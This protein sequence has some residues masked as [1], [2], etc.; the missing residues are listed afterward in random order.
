MFFLYYDVL[1]EMF[2]FKDVSNEVK[3]GYLTDY[4]NIIFSNP[5]T[6]F[7]GQGIGSYSYWS[8]LGIYTSITELTFFEL[9]RNYGLIGGSILL[10]LVL[11]PLIYLLDESKKEIHYLLLGYLSYLFM[12]FFNPI[13]F[14]SSG[15]MILS[16]IM[17]KILSLKKV[18]PF[19]GY[20]LNTT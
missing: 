12:A 15:M 1:S 6:F 14:S 13:F 16:V 3:I 2:S 4:A 11:F 7:F 8:V 5:L 19:N 17:A 20:L 18:V 9:F 10:F